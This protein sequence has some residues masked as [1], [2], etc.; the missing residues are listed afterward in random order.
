M[1]KKLLEYIRNNPIIYSYLREDSS[2]YRY[3]LR[4]SSYIKKIEELAKEKYKQRG[5]D[6]I[7]NLGDKLDFIKMFL[8]VFN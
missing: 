7:E 6:K 5:I 1:D 2:H 8:D 4:D 3:L